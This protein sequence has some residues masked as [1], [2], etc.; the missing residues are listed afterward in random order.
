MGLER[1]K[2]KPIVDLLLSL[3]QIVVVGAGRF[4]Q[5]FCKGQKLVRLWLVQAGGLGVAHI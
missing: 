5:C 4:G 1:E 2:V 3:F